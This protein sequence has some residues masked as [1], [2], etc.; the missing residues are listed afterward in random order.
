M[1]FYEQNIYQVMIFKLY[2][3]YNKHEVI[4][5]G[6]QTWEKLEVLAQVFE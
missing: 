6:G 4:K 2:T 3:I 5:I 1:Q